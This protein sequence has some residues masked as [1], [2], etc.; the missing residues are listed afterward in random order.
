MA[1]YFRPKLESLFNPLNFSNQT[2]EYKDVTT[3]FENTSSINLISDDITDYLTIKDSLIKQNNDELS[4]TTDDGY[5]L[6]IS[7]NKATSGDVYFNEN[8]YN[9]NVNI[10]NGSLNIWNGILNLNNGS[11]LLDGADIN[12]VLNGNKYELSVQADSLAIQNN[13]IQGHSVSIQESV[14]TGTI[15]STQIVT[16]Q[17]NYAPIDQPVFST[18]MTIPSIIIANNENVTDIQ[19]SHLKNVNSD[20]QGSLNTI[21]S[22]IGTIQTTQISDQN[23]ISTLQTN[24][25]TL[26]SKQV[27]DFNNIT[28]LQTSVSTLNTKQIQDEQNIST[29][30]SNL[31][32]VT[33]NQIADKINITNLQNA[34]V[35]DESNISVLQSSVSTL[36]NK[37]VVDFNNITELQN[38]VPTKANIISPTFSGIPQ[39]PTASINSNNLQIANTSYVDSSISNLIGSSPSLL[40]TLQEINTAINNDPNFSTTMLNQLALKANI[41]NPSFTIGLT[42]PAIDLNGSDLETSINSKQ[43]Q[44]DS[45]NTSVNT[46][47]TNISGISY[48]PLIGTTVNNNLVT[49]SI[50]DNGSLVSITN[51][52]TVS[53]SVNLPV[54][55]LSTGTINNNGYFAL[56]SDL[57]N[58][59]LTSTASSTYALISSLSSYVTTTNLNSTLLNYITS[60]ALNSTLSN[61]V[62]STTLSNYALITSLSDYLTI[63]NASTVYQTITGMSSY[64]TTSNA[65]LT[66][67]PISGMTNYLTSTLASATY[68][69]AINLTSTLSSYVTSASLTSTLSSYVTSSTLS[70]TLGNYAL[71][72]A[73]SSYALVSSLSSY[74][75]SSSLTTTL[76]DYITS[77][78]L[79]TTLNSYALSSSLSSYAL[80]SSLSSYVTSSS[81]TTTLSNYALSSSL[82]SYALASSL[83]AYVTSSSLT[84][85][86]SSYVLSSALSSYA[87][88]SALS[89]YLTT[90]TASSTYATLTSISNI[91][92]GTSSFTGFTNSGITNLNGTVNILRLSDT[93][94]SVT[95]TSGIATCNY[96]NGAVFFI[97]GQTAN[98]NLTLSNLTP[99]ANKAYSIT[100]I[101]SAS[102]SKF[103][104]TTLTIGSTSTSFVY[105]GG[106]TN[107]S[108]SSATYII[109]QFNIVYTAS[110]S[111]PA[112][113]ITSISSAF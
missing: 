91:L 53:G 101:I 59:L 45:L 17:N 31:S 57:S 24:V 60:S 2:I 13:Q 12:A 109:Q 113:T 51:G 87:L 15:N 46:I 34:L 99:V 98:F 8:S 75:T 55:S 68:V 32:T 66:F 93:L 107:V 22:S 18:S 25:G 27:I 89:S 43:I 6:H 26:T 84:T 50:T 63:T 21:N 23:N 36:T 16:I 38:T 77:N 88:T 69:T 111:S 72:S 1:K 64:L 14:D 37:Q 47:N 94:S 76:S 81:L 5:A 100:L 49:K 85:T 20:I 39:A 62:L 42:T 61:Y 82:S 79:T 83:S 78:S 35:I 80:A 92:N 48:N 9:S 30:Q 96:N 86:L 19:I 105:N 4:I 106:L 108:V 33:S 3:T 70:T 29:L 110:T 52:L 90:S 56:A 58:Y 95:V 71:S 11:I 54:N 103:Y 104:A 97:T 73:L 67:Q 10:M 74:V 112:F 65:N 28:N 44:I 7:N 102:S 41:N 40:N